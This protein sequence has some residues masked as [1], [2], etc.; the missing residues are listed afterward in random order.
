MRHARARGIRGEATMADFPNRSH[1]PFY[2]E[3]E[4]YFERLLEFLRAHPSR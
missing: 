1:T 2:E 4:P 3:P